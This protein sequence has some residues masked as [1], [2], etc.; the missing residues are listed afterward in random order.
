[1]YGAVATVG[2]GVCEDVGSRDAEQGV[3]PGEW[4]EA[5]AGGDGDLMSVS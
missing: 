2:G 3:L 5:G 4:V 1:M